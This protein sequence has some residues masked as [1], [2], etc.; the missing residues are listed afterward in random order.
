MPWRQLWL[1][2][3][4]QRGGGGLTHTSEHQSRCVFFPSTHHHCD[5]TPQP[6][7]SALTSESATLLP[8]LQLNR[9]TSESSLAPIPHPCSPPPPPPRQPLESALTTKSATL[10]SFVSA[11]RA[12]DAAAGDPSPPFD[13]KREKA[14]LANA[15]AAL[16]EQLTAETKPAV[17]LHL[18]ALLLEIDLNGGETQFRRPQ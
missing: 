2:V 9:R 10:L 16:R 5:I 11:A 8:F 4:W 13:K 1:G 18:V 3:A 14:A 7:E 17:C 15:R 12:A 6:L